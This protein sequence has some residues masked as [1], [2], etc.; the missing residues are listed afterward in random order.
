MTKQQAIDSLRLIRNQLDKLPIQ[1]ETPID[2]DLANA[3]Q[4]VYELWGHIEE[5]K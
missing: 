3:Y 1:E 5:T 2:D 4:I